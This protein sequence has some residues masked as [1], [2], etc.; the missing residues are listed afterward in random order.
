MTAAAEALVL[1][2][3]I[4]D[5]APRRHLDIVPSRAQKRARPR[6]Y[7]AIAAVAGIGA[8]LLAQ[9]LLSIVL[10]DGAYQISALQVAKRDLVREQHAATEELQKLS[11]T[12]NLQQNAAALG[13]VVSGTPLFLDLQSGQALGQ[14]GAPK[15][16]IVGA[17]GNHVGNVLLDG[18]TVIG[19]QT[20]QEAEAPSIATSPVAGIEA[21]EGAETGESALPGVAPGQ[22]TAGTIPSPVTR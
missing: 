13:M 2:V 22:T 5:E 7:G 16:Q 14:A 21:V 10:A 19:A 4:P 15:G 3:P 11:S 20:E 8:I 1:P 9:L 12:Q 6:L 17:Y 18:T